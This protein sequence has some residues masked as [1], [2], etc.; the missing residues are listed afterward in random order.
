MVLRTYFFW[1]F[2]G[3]IGYNKF[4]LGFEAFL[5]SVHRSIIALCEVRAEEWLA[6]LEG[7]TEACHLE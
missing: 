5:M 7:L 1:C 2:I 6:L 3:N 4:L